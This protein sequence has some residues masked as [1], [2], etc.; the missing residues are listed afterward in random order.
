MG[1]SDVAGPLAKV[2]TLALTCRGAPS[3][4]E[5]W[6]EDGRMFYVRVR[7]GEPEVRLSAEPTSDVMDA[8]HAAPVLALDL[9]DPWVSV[10]EEKAMRAVTASVLDF[11]QVGPATV[12][13]NI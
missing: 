11:S 5:G 12:G 6:L 3:Q 10:M 8:V 9:S 13:P 7:H 4:W 2:P 1:E